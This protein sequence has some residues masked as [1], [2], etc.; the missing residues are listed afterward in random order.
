M[1]TFLKGTITRLLQQQLSKFIKDINVDSFG[2]VGD[3][4]LYDLELRL[5]VLQAQLDELGIPLELRRGFVQKLSIAV[6]WFQLVSKPVAVRISAVEVVVTALTP[7]R[8]AER[9][10]AA[11]AAKSAK[12]EGSP[13]TKRGSAD[14]DSRS[15][16]R[17]RA[18]RRSP[19][20]RTALAF[21]L[22]AGFATGDFGADGL[23]DDES[24]D[25]SPSPVHEAPRARAGSDERNAAAPRK[26]R[27]WVERHVR[28]ILANATISVENIVIKY[29]QADA[30]CSVLARSVHIF[31][32][33][34]PAPP[35]K[36]ASA[37]AGGC[38]GG[39][40]GSGGGGGAAISTKER[41]RRSSLATLPSTASFQTSWTPRFQPPSE[42]LGRMHKVFELFELT[43]TLEPS[44]ASRRGPHLS[45]LQLRPPFEVPVLE[46]TSVYASGEFYLPLHFTRIMLTI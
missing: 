28:S 12:A 18:E 30:V 7:A 27:G 40:D 33:D 31:S 17:E 5:D 37:S 13:S 42:T 29:M 26:P 23:F 15:G 43:V 21:D 8:A 11:A 22:S 39:A 1:K 9:A 35:V 32:A 6:P 25:R 38:R 41:R 36:L 19:I 4:V 3:F 24:H 16:R 45:A 14:S 44:R 10:A 2:I 34:P 46:R 20:K